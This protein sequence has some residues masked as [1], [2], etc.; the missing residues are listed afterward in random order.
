MTA[1][2]HREKRGGARSAARLAAAQALFQLEQDPE[3]TPG[4]V[5]AQFRAH[6]LGKEVD[7]S[8]YAEADAAFFEDIVMGASGRCTEIDD[9]VT[10]ALSAGWRVGRLDSVLRAILRA[11]CYEILA[12][13]DVPTP[14]VI[15]EYV[16][17]AHAF[18]EGSEPGFVNGVLDAIARSLRGRE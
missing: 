5:V 9:H 6:R 8:L 2:E 7:G 17:V 10:G 3:A 1:A 13:P 12:R 18:F 16:D 14:S 15:N 4:S 11:G